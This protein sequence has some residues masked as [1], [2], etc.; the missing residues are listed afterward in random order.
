MKKHFLIGSVVALL[1]SVSAIPAL[2][3]DN[4]SKC[5]SIFKDLNLTA[6]QQQKIST[7]RQSMKNDPQR[8]QMRAKFAELKK[9]KEQ[10]PVDQN[11]VNAKIKEIKDLRAQSVGK[12][13]SSFDQFKAVLTPAQLAKL[14]ADYKNHPAG[15]GHFTGKH[16]FGEFK[17]WAKHSNSNDLF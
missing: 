3:F 15:R 1:I 11:L 5:T 14:K 9:L 13:K 12:N 10:K 16:G 7:I 2:A 8:V 4:G 6:A 17:G